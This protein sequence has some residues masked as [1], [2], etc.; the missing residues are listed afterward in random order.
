M[1]P[2]HHLNCE[3]NLP[4]GTNKITIPG[5]TFQVNGTTAE[6][7][8][9]TYINIQIIETHMLVKPFDTEQKV[10]SEMTDRFG[11]L[12]DPHSKSLHA[13]ITKLYGDS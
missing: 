11:S 5:L 6:Q 13:V 10:G 4:R 7:Q 1:K 8:Q 12:T 9:C 3:P 2:N